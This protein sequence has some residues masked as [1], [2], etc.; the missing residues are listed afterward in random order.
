MTKFPNAP[1][2]KP[3]TNDKWLVMDDFVCAF[4]GTIVI[5]RKDFQTDGASIPNTPMIRWLIG[6]PF[7]MPLLPCALVHDALYA[8][9]LLSRKECDWLFLELMK[10]AGIGWLKRNI[11]WTAVRAGGAFVWSRHSKSSVQKARLYCSCNHARK[12]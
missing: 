3:I 12:R 8:G 4:K 2:L 6:H 10:R 5:V 9:E 7:S 1:T 11:V